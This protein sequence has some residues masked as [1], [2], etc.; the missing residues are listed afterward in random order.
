MSGIRRLNCFA[1]SQSHGVSRVAFQ[2]AISDLS[3]A[4]LIAWMTIGIPG[5]KNKLVSPFPCRR[6]ELWAFACECT[7]VCISHLSSVWLGLGLSGSRIETLQT[8]LAPRTSQWTL[9]KS[10]IYVHLKFLCNEYTI[11]R[12]DF[13]GSKF[14]TWSRLVFRRRSCL[15]S[16]F[17]K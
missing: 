7:R 10:I 8:H 13:P 5:D 16:C 2:A 4:D 17:Y 9:I 3:R 14:C 15:W 12:S 1:R 6:F 11:S